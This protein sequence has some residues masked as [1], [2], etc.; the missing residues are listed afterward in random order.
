MKPP[1]RLIIAL[2]L[3]GIL[4]GVWASRRFSNR[5]DD[6]NMSARNGLGSNKLTADEQALL[7][8]TERLLQRESH[9]DQTLWAPELEARRHGDYFVQIW[10][11]LRSAPDKLAALSA[12]QFESLKHGKWK[13]SANYDHG[14]SRLTQDGP[15]QNLQFKE[16]E[17]RLRQ[18]RQDGWILDQT[19]WRH[20]AFIPSTDSSVPSRS[21]YWVSFHARNSATMERIQCSGRISIEWNEG[22]ESPTPGRIDATQLELLRS[23]NPPAFQKRLS[24]TIMP[25]EKTHFIDPLLVYD[26]NHDGLSEIILAARNLVLVNHGGF[27][28]ES[29]PLYPPPTHLIF[30]ALIADVNRDGFEDFLCVD[31]RGLL[32][33]AGNKAAWFE[34]EP[35]RLWLAP[36]RIEYGQVL[37][38]GDI[39][40]DGDLDL[41]LGQYKPPYVQGQMPTPVYD[42]NDGY[43]SYLLV[44][45]GNSEFIDATES[46]GLGKIRRRIY[47]SSLI[48]LDDDQ[49]L[50]LVIVSD[51]AGVD[52]YENDGQGH[53]T[54]ITQQALSDRTGFGMAHAFGDFNNDQ[55]MDFCMIGMNAPVA[56]QLDSLGLGHPDFPDYTQNRPD[57]TYGNRFYLRE[58]N[59]FEQA[60]FNDQ[61]AHSGW[62]WGVTAF[63]YDNDSDLDFYIA[64]GHST[65]A[66][67]LDYDPQFWTHDIYVANSEDDPV[68]DLYFKNETL[69]L[70]KLGASRGGNER[71]RL[72]QNEAGAAFPETGYLNDVALP[73]DSRDVVSDDLDGDGRPDLIVTTFEVW[74]E[75]R[76]TLQI[77]QNT[78]E[79]PNHWIS[80]QLRNANGGISPLGAKITVTTDQGR[81]SRWLTTGDSYRSQHSATLHFGLNNATQVENAEVLW[82]DGHLT[83]LEH[84]A[85]DQVHVI[86]R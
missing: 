36:Q 20:I 13:L 41:W 49:D 76:Q 69:R 60:P 1:L 35:K 48:D 62:S 68:A 27:E 2:V 58:G 14:V 33:Y 29:R 67:T 19:E 59:R 54:D 64:N 10:N 46:S 55:K 42:A 17:P 70:Q 51:F 86:S 6:S 66:S 43:P 9:L 77:F 21:V 74:P 25:F 26:L 4:V 18:L 72:Y 83:Q 5:A 65:E 47:S 3:L 61:L 82:P 30:T 73:Q 28:F 79:S 85:L 22:G 71:N 32:M 57:L 75:Y 44:N 45:N 52:L 39:D 78:L 24:Q 31:R 8:Q 15:F 53:F 63:D 37:T 16:F 23:H 38:A 50:D 56:S 12:L 34:G 80:F 11:K 84:P 40:Q 7:D 81:Q